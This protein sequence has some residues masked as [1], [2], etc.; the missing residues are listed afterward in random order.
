MWYLAVADAD[1][2]LV[3]IDVLADEIREAELGGEKHGGRVV[4]YIHS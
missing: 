2:L 4:L 3:V 1:E